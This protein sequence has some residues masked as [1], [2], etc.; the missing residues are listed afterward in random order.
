[1]LTSPITALIIGYLLGSLPFGYLV[2]RARGVNIFAVGSRN[3]GATNVGREVGPWWGRL[4]L[5]LDAIKG[6]VATA[7]PLFH[8]TWAIEDGRLTSLQWAFVNGE[9]GPTNMAV[10]GLVGALLG[11]SFSCF[12]R[13]RG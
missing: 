12:T 8:F 2:A 5:L 11:H 4:V 13:F 6:M 3:P 10:A 9:P 7:W 1:M